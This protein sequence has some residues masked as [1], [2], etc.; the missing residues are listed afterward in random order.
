MIAFFYTSSLSFVDLSMA[1]AILG[2]LI[3]LNRLRV[4][5]LLPYLVGGFFM[6]YFMINSGVH[7]TITG[8]LL[9]GAIPF[10]NGKEKSPSFVLQH[11]LH[12]PVAFFILPLFA[13]ANTC[14]PIVSHWE[15]GFGQ[16][17]SLGIIAGL[18]AGK[19]MGILLFSLIGVTLGFCALPRDL[20]WRHLA[21]A[22]FLGGIGFTM[23]VF[24]TLLAFQSRSEERRV[25]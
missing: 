13:M 5:A 20:R 12:K 2:L 21:G 24:I 18:V 10:G 23:S 17:Q 16:P 14:I 1:L 25:G 3:L 11:L 9:A 4:Y 8:V 15:D 7:A 22:G 19:P 6:W